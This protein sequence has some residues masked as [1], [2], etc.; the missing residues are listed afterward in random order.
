[1]RAIESPY[2]STVAWR[3][4]SASYSAS[5]RTAD[6]ENNLP[7]SRDAVVARRSLKAAVGEG[8]VSKL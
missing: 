3:D 2:A 8:P 1:V 4:S 6:H 5:R 7:I